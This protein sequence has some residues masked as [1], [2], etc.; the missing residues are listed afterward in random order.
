MLCLIFY[1]VKN[2]FFQISVSPLKPHP[3]RFRQGCILFVCS[4]VGLVGHCENELAA[5]HQLFVGD[6][7]AVKGLTVEGYAAD[8]NI[9]FALVECRHFQ[10]VAV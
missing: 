4:V 1:F 8:I 2:G 6:I 7:T 3:R 5:V 9:L 10:S